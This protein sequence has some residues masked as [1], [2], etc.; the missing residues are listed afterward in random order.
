MAQYNVYQE[1]TFPSPFAQAW[2][3]YKNNH[4]AWVA[5]WCV[6]LYIFIAIFGP[7]FSPYPPDL[8]HPE[9]VL[10]PPSWSDEGHV[11]FLLGTDDLGRDFLSR[12][13]HGTRLTFGSS[14]IIAFCAMIVGSTLGALAGMS[15]GLKSSLVN[16]VLDAILSIPSL[17][18]AI[19]IIA[20]LG[21]GFANAIWAVFLALI[22]QFIHTTRTAIRREK[23]KEYVT[24]AKLD[25]ANNWQLLTHAIFPNLV[26]TM[27]LYFTFAVSTAMLDIAALGFLGLGAEHSSPEWG[28]LFRSA[29]EVLYKGSWLIILPGINMFI[30]LTSINI[31]GNSIRQALKFRSS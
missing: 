23:Q 30:C 28:N 8:Q 29:V 12:L 7:L 6:G 26:D 19:I 17:L 27:L 18:L 5:L 20:I 10:L 15:S 11:Q 1:D 14:I 21:P 25:G 16:H 3:N 9:H 4:I 24:A 13:L 31:M 2:Q 22:P